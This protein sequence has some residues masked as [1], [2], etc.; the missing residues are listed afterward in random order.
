MKKVKFFIVMS[1]IITSSV[2]VFSSCG[3]DLLMDTDKCAEVA[4]EYLENKYQTE[5]EVVSSGEKGGVFGKSGYA[6]VKVKNNLEEGENEYIVVVYPDGSEDK[7]DDSRYDSYKVISD[8]YMCYLIQGYAKNEIDKLLMEAGLTRFISSVSIEEMV[9][10][11]GF[12]GFSSD[13]PLQSEEN[14]SLK[15]ILDKHIISMHCWLEVPENEDDYMFQN[16]IT[17]IVQPLL[18]EDL[19]TFDVEIY[20]DEHYDEVEECEKN[21]IERIVRGDKS[22][23]FAVKEED[24]N[25]SGK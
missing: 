16:N 13:F 23:Y 11:E 2:L 3:N 6:Y 25:E 18:S 9:G 15:N 1:M 22:I 10:V 21:N 12:W 4:L 7:D 8:T 14:F 17:N 20:Y 5:F 19:I 24:E